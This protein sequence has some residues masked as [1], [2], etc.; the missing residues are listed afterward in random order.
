MYLSFI[1]EGWLHQAKKSSA[2]RLQSYTLHET[3][4]LLF[5]YKFYDTLYNKGNFWISGTELHQNL[6]LFQWGDG[7]DRAMREKLRLLGVLTNSGAM[8]FLLAPLRPFHSSIHHPYALVHKTEESVG[9]EDKA[10]CTLTDIKPKSSNTFISGKNSI[11]I[12]H[13]CL[14]NSLFSPQN[15]LGSRIRWEFTCPEGLWPKV[16]GPWSLYKA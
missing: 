11:D 12:A 7:K 14:Y 3:V 4:N 6:L 10:T 15:T 1:I 13:T 9:F 16:A 5:G 2:P 8:H